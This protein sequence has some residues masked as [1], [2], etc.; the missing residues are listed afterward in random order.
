MEYMREGSYS[1]PDGSN[2][3]ELEYDWEAIRWLLDTYAEIR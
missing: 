1:W 2:V 3:I